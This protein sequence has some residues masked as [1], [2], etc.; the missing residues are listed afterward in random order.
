MA[1]L[2]AFPDA[3]WRLPLSNEQNRGQTPDP[4]RREDQLESSRPLDSQNIGNV[5]Y[6]GFR[7]SL[8]P[9]NVHHNTLPSHTPT[10]PMDQSSQ[11]NFDQSF[12]AS[13]K[14]DL[15]FAWCREGRS[16]VQDVNSIATHN[17]EYMDPN[18]E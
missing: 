6:P 10:N 7:P 3:N 16:I 14:N 5:F 1:D 15:A 2:F 11:D 13:P 8:A 9:S 4:G 18:F 12:H 17:V